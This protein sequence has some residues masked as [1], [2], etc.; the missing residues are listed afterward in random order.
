MKLIIGLGNPG[1]E[2][3][4]TRHNVGFMVIDNY[5][6]DVKWKEKFQADYYETLINNEKIIFIK[7][8]TYMNLS[9]NSVVQFVNY[10][11]VDIKDIL[12]IHDDL[13]L[14]LGR[15]K[16]KINSS[17]GGHNGIKSIISNLNSNGFLRLKVGIANDKSIDTKDFVL[18]RF[19]KTQLQLITDNYTKFNDI[20]E[21]FVINGIDR[22]INIYNTK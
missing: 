21:S 16:L 2:Y 17:S 3:E 9:G 18:G 1:K 13:D 15:F 11:N 22:T 4:C 12:V 10:Y 6:G 14:N 7:P 8:L 20:I 19:N 5:V